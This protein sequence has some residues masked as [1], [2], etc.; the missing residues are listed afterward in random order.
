MLRR[1]SQTALTAA[2]RSY[3]RAFHSGA[4][5]AM[6]AQPLVAPDALHDVI[7]A[8]LDA[9]KEAGTWKVERVIISPQ[10]ATVGERRL[11]Q[12]LPPLPRAGAPLFGSAAPAGAAPMPA[13]AVHSTRAAAI[14]QNP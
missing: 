2:W 13:C 3:S 14:P 9:M 6:A 4:P 8:Q 5:A 12:L 10:G 1:P 7:S 11:K